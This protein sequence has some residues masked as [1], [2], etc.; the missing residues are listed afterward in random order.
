MDS[1]R[2]HPASVDGAHIGLAP[3][4]IVFSGLISTDGAGVHDGNQVLGA[5]I[6]NL[7]LELSVAIDAAEQ[8]Q[9]VLAGP[10]QWVQRDLKRLARPWDM[11]H[12][13]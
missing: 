4:A 7:N 11:V 8:S 3:L 1:D 9:A 12:L 2:I 5:E 13:I 6:M 10:T